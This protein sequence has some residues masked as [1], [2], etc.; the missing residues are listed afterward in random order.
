V[1]QIV[2]KLNRGVPVR[3]AGK[4]KALKPIVFPVE[5][6][7]VQI[8]VRGP[9]PGWVDVR[10]LQV[11]PLPEMNRSNP[12]RSV[13]V[14]VEQKPTLCRALDRRLADDLGPGGKFGWLLEIALK[15]QLKTVMIRPAPL[16]T[17]ELLQ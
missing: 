17:V 10:R 8:A 6:D 16:V 7:Q 13:G 11:F 14:T 2:T 15:Q 12:L 5:R 4:T 9:C 1:S 3:I